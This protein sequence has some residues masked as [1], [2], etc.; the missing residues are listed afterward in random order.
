MS[1][2]W[3]LRDVESNWYERL[4]HKQEED[5]AEALQMMQEEQDE[6][7]RERQQRSCEQMEKKQITSPNKTKKTNTHIPTTRAANANKMKKKPAAN[8]IAPVSDSALDKEEPAGAIETQPVE[9]K[10]KYARVDQPGQAIPHGTGDYHGE[11]GG[12]RRTLRFEE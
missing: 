1:P 7:E 3:I 8:R 11:H 10:T 6:E 12:V 5:Q 2:T 9:R 4:L